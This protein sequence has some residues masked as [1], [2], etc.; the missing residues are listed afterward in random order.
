[1]LSLGK[2]RLQSRTSHR[3]HMGNDRRS[4]RQISIRYPAGGVGGG[5]KVG[6]Q[7]G[8]DRTPLISLVYIG[9]FPEYREILQM[10]QR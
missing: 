7:L 5:I 9:F 10:N 3:L 1:M 4:R 6:L 2:V 8:P